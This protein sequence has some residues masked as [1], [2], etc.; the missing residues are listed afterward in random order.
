V[1]EARD[2]YEEAFRRVLVD[3]VSQG[4]FRSD[5]DVRMSTIYILSILN[6]LDRWYRVDG[7]LD[8]PALVRSLMTFVLDGIAGR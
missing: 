2:R 4:A 5:L 1:V 6:A 3:G 7:D 8:R